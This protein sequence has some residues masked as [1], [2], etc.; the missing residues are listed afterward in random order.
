M[1]NDDTLVTDTDEDTKLDGILAKAD[2]L[3][4]E[5]VEQQQFQSGPV[6]PT[7]LTPEMLEIWIRHSFNNS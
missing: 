7:E 1:N 3:A 4:A 6:L 5:L 2:E